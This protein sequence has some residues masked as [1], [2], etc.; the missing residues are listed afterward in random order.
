MAS[1]KITLP[2]EVSKFTLPDAHPYIARILQGFSES[3]RR[4]ARGSKKGIIDH[5]QTHH[6]VGMGAQAQDVSE[7]LAHTS[8]M[9]GLSERET[10]STWSQV[11]VLLCK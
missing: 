4:R 2:F 3:A 9:N 6:V 11:V 8:D 1:L 7:A 5:W 10:F